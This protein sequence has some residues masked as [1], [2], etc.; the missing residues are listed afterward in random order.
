MENLQKQ[1]ETLCADLDGN[2]TVVVR[3]LQTKKNIQINGGESFYV[4]S[5]IKMWLLWLFFM[6]EQQGKRSLE[7]KATLVFDRSIVNMG[8]CDLVND[9]IE[10]TYKDMLY[11]MVVLSDNHCT[12][13][14]IDT[15]TLEKVNAEIQRL[16]AKGTVFNKKMNAGTANVSTADDVADIFELFFISP[17][18]NEKNRALALEM[19]SNQRYNTKLPLHFKKKLY[20]DGNI[21]YHKTG[22]IALAEVDAGV[23]SMPKQAKNVVIVCM[24]KDLKDNIDG[25][26]FNNK[27]G[28][29]IYDY[30]NK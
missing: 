10:W 20:S 23:L 26:I 19:L 13:H 1:L 9:K 8:I 15:L 30:F 25:I 16:G 11:L 3:D 27:V 17:Q 21:F 4:A 7:D 6:E 18:L 29:A 22:E 24:A 5:V 2:A 28:D 12:N 14:I